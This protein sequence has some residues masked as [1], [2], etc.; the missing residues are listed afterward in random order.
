MAIGDDVRNPERESA[1]SVVATEVSYIAVST[2]HEE[3][4]PSRG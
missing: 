3:I 1:V 4:S 2:V